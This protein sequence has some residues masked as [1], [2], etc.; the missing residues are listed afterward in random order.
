MFFLK[1]HELMIIIRK[2]VLRLNRIIYLILLTIIIILPCFQSYST[3]GWP[4]DDEFEILGYNI[5]TYFDP[6]PGT[7]SSDKE[8]KGVINI[9]GEFTGYDLGIVVDS[10]VT[11]YENETIYSNE[12]I[13]R[14]VVVLNSSIKSHTEE[15]RLETPTSSGQFTVY[16]VIFFGW[17]EVISADLTGNKTIILDA[18]YQKLGFDLANIIIPGLIFL[19]C[20]CLIVIS[21]IGFK[22]VHKEKTID[23]NEINK[24]LDQMNILTKK[25]FTRAGDFKNLDP[26]LKR[27]LNQP[28]QFYLLENEKHELEMKLKKLKPKQDELDKIDK[29]LAEARN[30]ILNNDFF[31]FISSNFIHASRK[32]E[33]Y[34]PI[35]N[36]EAKVQELRNF[37]REGRWEELQ[38]LEKV[39]L[40]WRICESYIRETNDEEFFWVIDVDVEK[41][42]KLL[43][44]LIKSYS[45]IKADTRWPPDRNLILKTIEELRTEL[46]IINKSITT[47]RKSD[48]KSLKKYLKKCENLKKEAENNL[49]W[50]ESREED[51]DTD[52]VER[53]LRR[54]EKLINL[55]S[56]ELDLLK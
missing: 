20:I 49:K 28:G 35:D 9:T 7:I 53:N 32:R 38:D 47:M 41:E 16:M 2:N 11:I 18:D 50:L 4:S 26:S 27:I 55:V 17:R 30:P 31:K 37:L 45:Q 46:E 48:K 13:G 10:Y 52:I 56:T 12:D 44:D 14:R 42:A 19:F 22:K 1:G 15:I 8:I 39:E 33:N 3:N 34:P 29:T 23:I 36:V 6:L 24:K 40:A 25:Y 51:I 54:M 5:H 43:T 21:V